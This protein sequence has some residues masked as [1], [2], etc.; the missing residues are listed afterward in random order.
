MTSKKDNVNYSD[1]GIDID[2]IKSIQQLI[3][4]NISNTHKLLKTGNVM[5]G[6]GHYAGLIEIGK[7]IM[8]L[9]TDGVGSKILV[10]QQMNTYDTIGIDCVAMNVNDIICVGSRPLAYLSYIALQ[11]TND[12]LLKDITT[13][14]VKGAKSSN[15]AIVGG[16]TAIL[17]D[18]ITGNK[19]DYNFDLAGM[20][21]GI[22]DNKKDLILGDK[23][24][25]N[26]YIIGINSSGLHSNGYTLARKILLDKYDINDKPEFL[27]SSIGNEL[28]RP[29]T[30]Y[31]RAI[32][33]LIEEF[34]A[35]IHGLA[36]ITGG[37]FT[38][39]KRLNHN[40]DYLL[41]N[42]PPISGIFRRIMVDGN[43]STREM[44]RTFNMGIGFCVIAPKK[45]AENIIQ[46]IRSEKMKCQIIGRIKGNGKGNVLINSAQSKTNLKRA[47]MDLL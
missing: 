16:E 38:K 41:D 46:I 35:K 4:K 22:I 34:S 32:L 6:Y 44:Y 33:K 45:E 8:T 30:I 23:I 5:S 28:L 21:F 26:D 11:K 3:G 7:K 14:L 10:A 43:I 27:K 36:H 31:S 20:I 29:T 47:P 18:I 19:R 12:V 15:V 37:A 13:G 9:H 17:P 40:V 24:R 39:L 1:L 42:L 25:N 2:K